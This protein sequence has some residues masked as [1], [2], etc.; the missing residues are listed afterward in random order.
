[1][2]FAKETHFLNADKSKTVK[3]DSPDAAFLLVREGMEISEEDAKTY[4]V[5][6]SDEAPD[7]ESKAVES[8][9]E[10][11]AVEMPKKAAVKVR[12]GKK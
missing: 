6:T 10:N 3:E 1:M 7:V 5:K 11:K 8:T 4:G 12:K 9:P 2:P